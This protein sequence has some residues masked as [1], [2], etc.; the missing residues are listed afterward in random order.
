[1]K[2][3]ICFVLLSLFVLGLLPNQNK[4]ANGQINID[5]I[6]VPS[7]VPIADQDTYRIQAAIDVAHK[8]TFRAGL[9]SRVI[10]PAGKVENQQYKT[11]KYRLTQTITIKG[12][13]VLS[14]DSAVRRGVRLQWDNVR[15]DQPLLKFHNCHGG[16]LENIALA[17]SSLA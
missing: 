12:G 1:M 7:T 8:A 17:V 9:S 2:A 5:S 14:T 13:V 4:L 6:F 15:D 16:G 3:K 10:I 11:R